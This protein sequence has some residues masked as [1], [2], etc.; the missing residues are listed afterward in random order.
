MPDPGANNGSVSLAV[1]HPFSIHT[2]VIAPATARSV[3]PD[4][5]HHFI[6]TRWASARR[7]RCF[8]DELDLAIVFDLAQRHRE[9]GYVAG[10]R[11][12][13]WFPLWPR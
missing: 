7:R 9:G 5:T 13:V 1:A 10:L 3:M 2:A 11:R 4:F 8:L 6:I 12:F